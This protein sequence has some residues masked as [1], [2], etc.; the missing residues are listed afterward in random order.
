MP[1]CEPIIRSAVVEGSFE[2]LVRVLAR[3]A[4]PHAGTAPAA[5]K[6]GM[7]RL[8]L[9]RYDPPE[10]WAL[11]LRLAE[12]REAGAREVGALLLP[13]VC[14][15]RPTLALDPLARLAE[16]A[17]W[18]VREW[19]AG[20]LGALLAVN[21]EAVFPHLEAWTRTASDRLR[22]AVAIALMEYGKVCDPS[23]VDTVLN[24]AGSMLGDPSPYVQANL[25]PF[26]IGSGLAARFPEAVASYLR[27]WVQNDDEATR[28]QIALVFSASAGAR[29][30]PLAL[31][32]LDALGADRR[33]S[34][35]RAFEKARSRIAKGLLAS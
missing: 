32:V 18:E 10:A 27:R 3:L 4:T 12:S 29:L 7:A 17:N 21:F 28:R 24:L 8:L 25:G 22:R 6:R 14:E 13:E 9:G 19:A 30:A 23:R 1:S 16:N 26:A 20:A 2:D 33:P 5:V 31:D 15:G 34:V 11:A 35:Q